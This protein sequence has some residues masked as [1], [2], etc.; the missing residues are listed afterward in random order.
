LWA[1]LA[2]AISPDSGKDN[3]SEGSSKKR[4]RSSERA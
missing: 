2:A 4:G 3:T 1:E